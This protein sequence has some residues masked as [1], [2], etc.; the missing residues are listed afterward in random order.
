M[1][2]MKAS[3]LAVLLILPTASRMEAGAPEAAPS[4]GEKKTVVVVSPEPEVVVDDDGA[5]FEGEDGPETF[6]DL[7]DLENLPE[8]AWFEGGGYIGVRPIEM[9]PELRTHFGAPKEA[10]VF[11]GKVE[12]GSP[13]AKAGLQVADIVT[14]ADG[15]TIGSTRDLVRAVRRKREGD[16]VAIEL[17]RDGSRKTLTVTVAERE[18]KV[19][20]GDFEHGMRK[21]HWRGMPPVPPAPPVAPVPPGSPD[22]QDRIDELEKRI[23]A[24]ENRAPKN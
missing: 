14:A 3:L 22:L 1:R 5:F 23:D 10:G 7:R 8:L 21:F 13:A 9:T 6:A 15:E 4:S 16:T 19:R 24:L 12:K 11:V 2:L 18:G 17:V 20:V